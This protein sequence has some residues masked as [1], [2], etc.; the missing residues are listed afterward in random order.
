MLINL[1]Y[2]SNNENSA[3][4]MNYEFLLII[5]Y[6]INFSDSNDARDPYRDFITEKLIDRTTP[7]HEAVYSK[8]STYI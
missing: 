7:L 5:H 1:V 8:I 2:I 6:L 3:N 4:S